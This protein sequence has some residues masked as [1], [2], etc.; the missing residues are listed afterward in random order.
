MTNPVFQKI[1]IILGKPGKENL[2]RVCRTLSLLFAH[3]N[4]TS[5]LYLVTDNLPESMPQI[6]KI[7]KEIV[8]KIKGSKIKN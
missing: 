2:E 4:M 6:K 7:H 5:S 8:D 3:V 1:Y